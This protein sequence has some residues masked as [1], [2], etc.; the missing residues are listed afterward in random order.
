MYL[1][2]EHI[3]RLSSSLLH[4]DASIYD[5]NKEIEEVLDDMR[6]PNDVDAASLNL[7]ENIRWDLLVFIDSK[8]DCPNFKMYTSYFYTRNHI[9]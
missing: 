4:S 5:K 3:Q 7:Q 1:Y 6:L 8:Y 2:Y 9:D